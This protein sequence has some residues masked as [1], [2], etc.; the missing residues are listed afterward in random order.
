M[1]KVGKIDWKSVLSKL[2]PKKSI[3]PI[4]AGLQLSQW[5]TK[6]SVGSI[7]SQEDDSTPSFESS[8]AFVTE[9]ETNRCR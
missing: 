3:S 6:D 1:G 5:S 7:Y 8:S 9:R 4:E 2:A